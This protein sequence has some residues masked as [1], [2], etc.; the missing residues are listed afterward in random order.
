[1]LS[2]TRG[3]LKATVPMALV[4][5]YWQIQLEKN[6]KRAEIDMFISNIFELGL[7]KYEQKGGKNV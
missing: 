3:N 7:E 2:T 5:D 4:R 6:P 1:M